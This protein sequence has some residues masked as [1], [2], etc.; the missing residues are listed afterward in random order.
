MKV[1]GMVVAVLAM[2]VTANGAFTWSDGFESGDVSAWNGG[3]LANGGSV[4]T[5]GAGGLLPRT[6]NYMATL[7]AG[8]QGWGILDA[9]YPDDPMQGTFTGYMARS[10][11]L[12]PS[13]IVGMVIW[14]ADDGQSVAVQVTETGAVRYRYGGGLVYTGDILEPGEWLKVSMYSG[15]QGSLISIND[16]EYAATQTNKYWQHVFSFNEFFIG[17]AWTNVGADQWY[18]DDFS[19]VPEPTSIALLSLGVVSLLRRKK[20][21]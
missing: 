14:S 5:S 21:S 17:S 20:V 10:A 2:A 4:V 13:Q 18:F 9:Y 15:P 12:S 19:I 1:L 3:W 16:V 11:D 8:T 7:S 6:G